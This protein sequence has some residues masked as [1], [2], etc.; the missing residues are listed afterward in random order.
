MLDGPVDAIWIENLNTVLDDN[1][2]LTLANG[3][4]ILMSP[5]MKAMFEPDNLANASPATVSRAGIIYVSESELG[6]MPPVVSWLQT[7]PAYVLE[8]LQPLFDRYIE[9][10]LT[11]LRLSYKPVMHNEVACTLAAMR[12]LMDGCLGNSE[13]LAGSVQVPEMTLKRYFVYCMTWTLGG[14]LGVRE[15][16]LFDAD[17]RAVGAPPLPCLSLIHI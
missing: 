14:L 13:V 12:T 17:V 9:P 7:K 3:D 5:M 6:W 2:V 8:T 15:R 4:R 11:A 10:L 1:K 16:S